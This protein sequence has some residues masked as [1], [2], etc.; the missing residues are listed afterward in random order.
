VTASG[1]L[2]LL[3]PPSLPVILYGAVAGVAA[4]KLFFGGMVPGIILMLVVAAYAV[5]AG[6]AAKAPRQQF[7]FAEVTRALWSAKYDLGLPVVVLAAF[8]SGWATIVE[9]AA[10]GAAYALVVELAV[11]RDVDPLRKMP[12]VLVQSATL[13]GAVVILLGVALGLTSYLVDAQIPDALVEWVRA[14]FHAQWS[15]LLALNGLLLVLGSVFEIYAAI[16]VLAP[17]IAPLG[18]VFNVEPI[19]LG[20]VFLANLELG[21]LF[22]PMGLNLFLSASRFGKPLPYLYK[23]ALPFLLIM[24]VGVLFITYV[25]AITTGVAALLSR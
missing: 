23:Q 10:L 17:L 21:F 19:H 12:H 11:F 13:V 7:S 25:P 14:H 5:R 15:F 20:V 9:A 4:D 2:G 3:F 8:V 24:A 18:A 6:I 22:P 16:I 1:S